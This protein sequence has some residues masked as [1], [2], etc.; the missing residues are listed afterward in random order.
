VTTGLELA[1]MLVLYEL[2]IIAV[3]ILERRLPRRADQR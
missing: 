1:P 3:A 2:S